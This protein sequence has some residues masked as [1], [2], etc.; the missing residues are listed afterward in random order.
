MLRRSSELLGTSPGHESHVHFRAHTGGMKRGKYTYTCTSQQR[1]NG[2][3]LDSNRCQDIVLK[4]LTKDAIFTTFTIRTI[5]LFIYLFIC[6]VLNKVVNTWVRPH[7]ASNGWMSGEYWTI[8]KR[9]GAGRGLR[10]YS[11]MNLPGV[12]ENKP[13]NN[14]ATVFSVSA[15]LELDTFQTQIKSVTTWTNA[16]GCIYNILWLDVGKPE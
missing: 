5:C 12:T 2:E 8:K 16:L 7:M 6:G 3:N 1:W 14:S 13:W 15:R 10:N 11:G 4:L 9:E